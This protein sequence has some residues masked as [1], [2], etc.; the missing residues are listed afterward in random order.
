ME[1][2]IEKKNDEYI[3]STSVSNQTKQDEFIIE[4]YPK[5]KTPIDNGIKMTRNFEELI[6]FLEQLE[7]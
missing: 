7:E 5:N 3:F 4:F 2:L 6:D 1:N